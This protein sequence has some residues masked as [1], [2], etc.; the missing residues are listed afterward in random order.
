MV[1]K[2]KAR[3][4]R[5]PLRTIKKLATKRIWVKEPWYSIIDRLLEVP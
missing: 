1:L 5:I 4:V 2:E 3:Q